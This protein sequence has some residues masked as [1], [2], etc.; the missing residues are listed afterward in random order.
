MSNLHSFL[1]V[2]RTD[3]KPSHIS[4]IN[5][6]G[7]FLLRDED[8]KSFWELY[9]VFDQ[10]KGVGEMPN[11]PNLP[12]VVD[13]DLKKEIVENI[14]FLEKRVLYS[15][16]HVKVI[17][18]IYQKVLTEII[19]NLD[20]AHLVC[21]LLEKNAYLCQD[22]DKTF[23]K[24]GFHL[25]FPFIFLNK[26]V[27]QNDLIPRIYMEIKKL[28]A[29]ELPSVPNVENCIDKQY[30]KNAWL[31]YGSQKESNQPYFVT[32]ALN[33]QTQVV[34][35]WQDCF[36]NYQ[37][38]DHKGQK[39]SFDHLDIE[40][41][42][43]QIFSIS[44]N[45][46]ENYLYDIKND[47][48]SITSDNKTIGIKMKKIVYPE[49]IERTSKLVDDLLA[50]LSDERAEDRNEWMTIGWILFNIF[51]GIQ[52]GFDK[53]IEFSK[54]SSKY[55][56]SVCF[57]EW[58]KMKPRDYTIGSLKYIAREDNPELYKKALAEH[59]A[60][61]YD[62]CL[63]LDGTHHDLAN[64]L[65]QKYESDFV[66]A[67]L[68][69]KVWYQFDNNIWEKVDLGYTL[70]SK[71]SSEL[72]IEYE[73][74]WKDLISK[75]RAADEEEA[76]VLNKRLKQVQKLIYNLK[77]NS[78][79]NHIMAQAAEV[80]FCPPFYKKLDTNPYIVAFGNGVYD[81]QNHIFREGRPGDYL[82][83]KMNISYNDHYTE[84]CKEIKELHSFFE[85]IFPD[86]DVREYFLDHAAEIFIGRNRHKT[87]QFWTGK[88]NNGKSI[89]Q[90]IFEQMLGPY[91]IKL[92]TSLI[93]GKRTQS[94]AACPE[95]VRAGSGVRF[96]TLQ[97]PDKKDVLNI[98]I[99]KELSGNDT[100]FARG[101][102]KE[103]AEITPMFKPVLICN[104]PPIVPHNDKAFWNRVK[105]IPFE[106]TFDSELAPESFEEQVKQ[107][108]F[109]RDENF[110]DKI[111]RMLEPFAW[112]LLNR[113]K[114]K[115]MNKKE[116]L[117]VILA[118]N[119]Y[120]KKNDIFK[121]FVD[122]YVEEKEGKIITHLEMYSMF[123]DWQKE[124]CPNNPCPDRS[125]FMDYFIE[126]WGNCEKGVWKNKY[127]RGP[128]DN[129]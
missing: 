8:M 26:V 20:P 27:H 68:S 40:E 49:N 113:L 1:H 57:Y 32:C 95:L 69:H 124:S 67:S 58:N 7:K 100:F 121:Q 122:E 66:C 104:D 43:P 76:P 83:L 35:N 71:I 13:V 34:E 41:Y 103:G 12:I 70:S 74:I 75:F 38:F 92:P 89:T 48:P 25:H 118:T 46:R 52:E 64:V 54:R 44:L 81:L 78:Y 129:A 97:E 101:L 128:I 98:G 84:N 110:E 106:S 14:Q 29:S 111:P 90:N 59:T 79:K 80:F 55:Q 85:K 77:S 114:T 91:S 107:K 56:E 63:K 6:K 87:F 37:I 51:H 33:S 60:H 88:G 82:S 108:I 2:H 50:C 112:F 21:F 73:T 96:A 36:E 120:K 62:K 119:N 10:S 109:P 31:L 126:L 94:S 28:K 116:P 19:Q 61:L 117:K 47:L 15:I 65:Y 9:S 24:N 93:T 5:P 127:L 17:V 42:L 115:P 105:L 53:W 3:S 125:E 99:L 86:A 23:M 123:K 102:Y 22:K 39:I 18:G 11:T 72:V 45:H 30:I 16:D 4:M